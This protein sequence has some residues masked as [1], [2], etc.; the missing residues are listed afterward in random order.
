[1]SQWCHIMLQLCIL[2]KLY[3]L[4]QKQ[5]IQTIHQSMHLYI[6]GVPRGSRTMEDNTL[7]PW[8]PVYE[9]D[10]TFFGSSH[11]LGVPME[12]GCR[13]WQAMATREPNSTLQLTHLNPSACGAFELTAWLL[14]WAGLIMPVANKLSA[15][16]LSIY[17]G[18][19]NTQFSPAKWWKLNT[20]N[21]A[22]IVFHIKRDASVAY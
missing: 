10:L 17:G 2:W 6:L 13:R 16:G 9:M 3:T 22:T 11:G 19:L 18:N 4:F 21:E 12:V 1:M 20:T 14:R 7:A 5:K 8:R 15:P